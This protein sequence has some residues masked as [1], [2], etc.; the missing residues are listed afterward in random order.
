MKYHQFTDAE[1]LRVAREVELRGA[2]LYARAQKLDVSPDVMDMLKKL[3]ADELSHAIQFE[4]MMVEG[5]DMGMQDEYRPETSMF[6]SAIAGEVVFPGGVLAGISEA[7]FSSVG[8]LIRAAIAAEKDSLLYYY[9]AK[10]D[11]SL[12]LAE[13]LTRLIA[14]E[15]EHLSQ[16]QQML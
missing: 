10:E 7:Q 9:A 5:A 8:A 3:E 12:R 2:Q 1:M 6:L 4:R 11:A 14:E 13:A 15:R 16:L